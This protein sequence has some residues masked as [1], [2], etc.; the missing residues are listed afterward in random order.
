[1]VIDPP[2]L[3]IRRD[4]PRPDHELVAAFAN[5]ATGH[6]VDALGGAGALDYR[7]K[8]LGRGPSAF[9]GVALTCWAGPCDNLAVFGALDCA[10]IGDVVLAA[11]GPFFGAAVVGD[12]VIG[13][14]RNCGVAAFVTDGVVRD[15]AGIEAVGLPVACAGVSPNSPARN[16]PG[17]VGLPVVLGGVAVEAGDIVVGDADGV[18]VVPQARA[19]EIAA[20]LAVV[21]GAEA[22]VE[23]Q[24][25]A[26]ARM[27]ETL[28]PL[29]RSERVKNIR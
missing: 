6:V 5:A 13:M 26:G 20:R 29:L 23:A 15:V 28:R 3:T 2:L 24:V 19:R 14:M 4:F 27:L 7:I 18:V 17:A 16:G 22:E 10:R 12:L 9:H 1:M 8:P 25:R 11:T 21:R